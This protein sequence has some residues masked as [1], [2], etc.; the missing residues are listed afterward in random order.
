VPGGKWYEHHIISGNH[1]LSEFQGAVLNCQLDRLKE[2]T[3]LRDANGRYLDEKLS[4]IPGITPQRRDAFATK[5]AQHLYPFRFDASA[6]GTSR[7]RFLE[8]LAAEG[9]PA[10]PGYVIPLYRQPLFADKAF[11]PYTAG[12]DRDYG[13]IRLPVCER[14]CNEEGAWFYQTVL[15]GNR[16]D[17]D[18]VASAVAKVYEHREALAENKAQAVGAGR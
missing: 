17:M 8:A 14:I 11:G 9:I 16:S 12:G 7:Q 2:Q 3:D 5:S 18:D 10:A 15:L 6:F 1:R 13:S 4:Q